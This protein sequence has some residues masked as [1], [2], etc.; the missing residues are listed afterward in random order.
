MP[1]LISILSWVGIF[2]LYFIVEFV[3]NLF[4]TYKIAHVSEKDFKKAAL[5]GSISTFLFVFTTLLAMLFTSNIN[6]MNVL[7]VGDAS[8]GIQMWMQLTYLFITT[9]AFSM[10]NYCA[11]VSIPKLNKLLEGKKEN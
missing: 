9:L 8:D 10:G 4:F 5:A 7:F 3:I 1:I 11:T 2:L 6:L